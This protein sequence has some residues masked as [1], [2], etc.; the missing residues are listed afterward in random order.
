MHFTHNVIISLA[1]GIL[2]PAL[3]KPVTFD[4]KITL[5]D[6]GSATTTTSSGGGAG[7]VNEM[8]SSQYDTVFCNGTNY[9]ET[10]LDK[11]VCGDKRLGPKTLPREAPPLGSLLSSYSQLGGYSPGAFL[12]TWWNATGEKWLWPPQDGFTPDDDTDMAIKNDYELVVGVYVDRFGYEGGKFLAPF[13]TAY[14]QRALPPDS[15]DTPQDNP[16]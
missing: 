3:A 11:Y 1:A 14:V 8:V 12:E 5:N 2:S 7:T 13:E 6:D 16:R 10:L 4:V 9:N 15:L